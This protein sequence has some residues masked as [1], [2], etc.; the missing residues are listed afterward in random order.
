MPLAREFFFRRSSHMCDISCETEITHT[1]RYAKMLHDFLVQ[2]CGAQ[3]A[4]PTTANHQGH[5]HHPLR[6]SGMT[7][8]DAAMYDDES[9][10]ILNSLLT[11]NS[12]AIGPSMMDHFPGMN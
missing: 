12:P 6:D 2:S 8:H 1:D 4:G 10:S 7:A 11:M 3:W 9:T 5:H